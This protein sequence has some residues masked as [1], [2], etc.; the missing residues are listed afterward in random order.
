MDSRGRH[1]LVADFTNASRVGSGP[2]EL[3]RL[4]PPLLAAGLTG[5]QLTLVALLVELGQRYGRRATA[6]MPVEG[7]VRL[8]GCLERHDLGRGGDVRHDPRDP[9]DGLRGVGGIFDLV[10]DDLVDAPNVGFGLGIGLRGTTG[11]DAHGESFQLSAVCRT[12]RRCRSVLTSSCL[13]YT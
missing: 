11:E 9:R 5:A 8:T 2:G 7:F 4:E 1:G 10:G 13:L 3:L 12:A 6:A